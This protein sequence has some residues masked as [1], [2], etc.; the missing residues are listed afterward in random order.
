MMNNEHLDEHT[1]LKYR[2]VNF[3]LVIQFVGR[4]HQQ[5][6]QFLF[7]SP[8]F[9]MN[10]P[11]PPGPEQPEPDQPQGPGQLIRV[12]GI[13]ADLHAQQVVEDNYANNNRK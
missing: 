11:I 1:C 2:C 6:D 13:V 8:N 12:G 4:Q 7:Y 5:C 3:S 9:G 10:R